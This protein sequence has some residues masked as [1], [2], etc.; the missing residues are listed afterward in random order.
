MIGSRRPVAGRGEIVGRIEWERQGIT[1][2]EVIV[3]LC[4]FSLVLASASAILI[5]QQR[6]YS[7]NADVASTRSAARTAA[8]L[9]T[10]ELRGLSAAGG[11]LYGFA[12]DSL[13]IRSTTGVGI[14]CAVSG[15]TLVSR[16][17]SGVFGDLPTDS[18]VIFVE[19]ETNS[20]G[21]DELVVA[22]VEESRAASSPICPDGAPPDVALNL[23]RV[24]DGVGI[25]SPIRSFRPYVYKLYVGGDGRWWLGQRLRSG[26]T[27]PITG[28]F[29]PPAQGGLRLS[30]STPLGVAAV[31]PAAVAVVK[32]RVKA[33]GRLRYP[34]GGLKRVFTDT[35]TTAVW[36]R[37]Y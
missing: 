35:V 26:R 34:W 10:A 18:V 7:R 14:V 20:A 28:P 3:F 24:I 32:I 30:Y 4:L 1:T 9:L 22:R 27:Q 19:H 15:S 37:G 36:V 25:G 12:P 29:A 21:D 6:F 13:A 16:R 11:G 33:Q 23:D 8:E 5:G 17:V 31:E 2:L